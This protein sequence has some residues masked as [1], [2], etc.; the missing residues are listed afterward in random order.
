MLTPNSL[1]DN[2]FVMHSFVKL[3]YCDAKTLFAA[4]PSEIL[5]A[6]QY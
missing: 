6:Q 4:P 2:N 3:S 5:R 1:G